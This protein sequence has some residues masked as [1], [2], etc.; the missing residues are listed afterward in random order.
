MELEDLKI[1]IMGEIEKEKSIKYRYPDNI[2][3]A[4]N[5]GL[6]MAFGIVLGTN[7]T[8]DTY[9]EFAHAAIRK[10]KHKE[11][12]LSDP[13]NTVS[14]DTFYML[15]GMETACDIVEEMLNKINGD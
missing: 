15:L 14:T 3:P 11:N 7:N 2:E 9:D 4:V 5:L 1:L 6:T 10:I 12:T 13:K 8:L